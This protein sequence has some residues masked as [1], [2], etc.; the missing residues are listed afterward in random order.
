MAL[1]GKLSFTPPGILKVADTFCLSTV[2]V[3]VTGA[4]RFSEPAT[5]A[6]ISED[7]VVLLLKPKLAKVKISSLLGTIE[8][9]KPI[10]ISNP[11]SL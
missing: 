3:N 1:I 8:A 10:E 2:P 6:P 11:N 7:D 9:F 5:V 4:S